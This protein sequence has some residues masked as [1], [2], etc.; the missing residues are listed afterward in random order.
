MDPGATR[1]ICIA[2]C[3]A[4]PKQSVAI[5]MICVWTDRTVLHGF[6]GFQAKG[7]HVA[8][9]QRDS[10]HLSV[11]G[12]EKNGSVEPGPIPPLTFDEFAHKVV[13]AEGQYALRTNFEGL[14]S[15]RGAPARQYVRIASRVYKTPTPFITL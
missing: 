12:T 5:N 11:N 7:S 2:T 6:N 1:M 13:V 8:H 4:T 10:D 3:I 14:C 9:K 15:S